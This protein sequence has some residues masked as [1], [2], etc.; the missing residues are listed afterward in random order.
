[1]SNS[2][3]NASCLTTAGVEMSERGHS[4]SSLIQRAIGRVMAIVAT[5]VWL[6]ACSSQPP[7]SDESQNQQLGAASEQ[8]ESQMSAPQHIYPF[9][10][11]HRARYGTRFMSESQP[12]DDSTEDQSE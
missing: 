3:Q 4:L 10:T 7:A 11:V 9:E 8:S 1:M 6:T 12:T 5:G 2:C